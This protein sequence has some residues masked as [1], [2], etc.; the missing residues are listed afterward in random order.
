MPFTRTPRGKTPIRPRSGLTSTIRRIG[1]NA[2]GIAAAAL[3][4]AVF[5]AVSIAAAAPAAY[6]AAPSAAS[7]AAP[8][9]PA[10]APSAARRGPGGVSTVAQDLRGATFDVSPAA[11]RFDTTSVGGTVYSRI[12][13]PGGFAVEAPGR[14]AL[15][16]IDVHVAVPDGMSPRL[17]LSGERWDERS[18]PPPLPVAREIFLADDP[19]TGPSSEYRTEPEASIY[20]GAALY[21]TS[22]AEVGTG[23]MVGERWVAPIHVH[24]VRW[25]PRSRAYRVLR[26][27]TIRVD[28]VPATDQ[29]LRLRPAPRAG[30]QAP[31]WDRVQRGLVRNYEASRSFPIRPRPGAPG[32]AP[33]GGTGARARSALTANPEWRLSIAQTGWVSVSYATLAASGFPSGIPIANVRI[34]ERGYDDVGDSATATPIPVVA[35]DAGTPG[36]FDAGDAITFFARSVRDRFGAGNLELRYSDTNI[37]WLTYGAAAAPVVGTIPGTIGGTP[38]V[39]ASFRDVTRLEQNDFVMTTPNSAAASPPEA[40]DYLFWTTGEDP[41][42][43]DTTLPFTDPDPSQPFRIRARYQGQNGSTHRVDTFFQGAGGNSDTLA[44]GDLFFDQDVYLLDTGFTIP[45]SHIAAGTNHYRHVGARQNN[46]TGPFFA[47][48]RAR[49]DVIELTYNR[50]YVARNNLLRFTS[51]GSGGA[52][53]PHVAGFTSSAVEVYD[54]TNPLAPLRVTG[55]TVTPS[56]ATFTVSFQ[57]DATAGERTFVAFVP[58][59]ITNLTG[60]AVTADAPSNLRTPG[61]FGASSVA[62][63]VMIAP[64]AFLAP[65]QRLADYRRGQGYVV[66]LADVQDVYDE[67]NGGLKSARAIRRYL[68]NAYLNWSPRPTYVLLLGDGSLDYRHSMPTSAV[69]WIPT[70]LRFETIPDSRGLELVAHDSYYSLG[71]SNIDMGGSLAPSVFLGRIPASSATELDDYV[72]KA[73]QYE[74]YQPTDSWR[75]RQLLVA[76]DEFSTSI[77]FNLGYC[78]QPPETEFELASLQMADSTAAGTGGVDIENDFYH[79]STYTDPIPTTIDPFGQ[80][81]RSLATVLQTLSEPNGGYAQLAAALSRGNLITNFEAH[82]NRYLIAHE[83]LFCGSPVYCQA[84]VTMDQIENFGKPSLFMVWGCH[85]NQFPDGPFGAGTVDSTDAI[86]E[87]WLLASNRGAIASVGSTGY[88]Y[89]SNNNAYNQYVAQA[90]YNRT[91]A[92]PVTGRAEWI[93]GELLGDAA[94]RNSMGGGFDQQVM[95]RRILLLGDPMVRM[96]ALPPRIFQVTLDGAPFADLGALTTD[97]PTDSLAIVADM[98]DEVGIVSTAVTEQDLASGAVTPLDSALFTVAYSDS[99]RKASLTGKVRPHLG[100][101]DL[102]VRATDV[103][104]RVRIFAM[105][106]RTPIRYFANG[107]EIVNNVFVASSALL[108][109]EVTSPIPLTADSLELWLDGAPIS[110]SKTQTDAAGRKWTLESLSGNRSEGPHTIQ[111]AFNGRTAGFDQATFQI[112]SEFTLRGIAV[113]D[114]RVLASGCGGSVFQYELSAD[115][116]DVRLMVYTVAGRRVASIPLPGQAGFNVYCWNGRDSE[117]HEAAIGLYLFRIQATDMGGRTLTRQGRFIR[118]R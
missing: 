45:G 10:S 61:A 86:G 113:V 60:P 93:V 73:I 17:T 32:S 118:S 83:L 97:S 25:D 94:L 9:A 84:T 11:A 74:Q 66:E 54:V 22:A 21:P 79:L 116:R 107:V 67:F 56:G 42:V 26:S 70:Y 19:K 91:P 27:M 36:T 2:P 29:E 98:R 59:A 95:N 111:V 49:L 38:P 75:G 16:T 7:T 39:P 65:A 1:A 23:A 102:Q 37:Y 105:Q 46:G 92:D 89:L 106:V 81:C 69:D 88:E 90:L 50:L 48:S 114:S 40:I 76:D 31:V 104:G 33:F 15:P 87:Q 6:A 5:A 63:T 51:G 4:A 80:T 8:T 62:R 24:P 72:T 103:N 20:R 13:L 52:F 68:R 82:A 110:S 30:G 18:A 47:G 78:F 12:S 58:G 41:D 108:R 117:G 85:A 34:E 99:S 101:Y 64:A 44:I 96:D 71:L 77:F 55:V 115:A 35:R 109:A 100:N 3:S 43:F 28:F 112:T 57:T 53:E 14:P